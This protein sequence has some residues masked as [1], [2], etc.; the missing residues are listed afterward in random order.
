MRAVTSNDIRKLRYDKDAWRSYHRN[1]IELVV[2]PDGILF[3]RNEMGGVY[4]VPLDPKSE[5]ICIIRESNSSAHGLALSKDGT[6]Y[7]RSGDG[8]TIVLDVAYKI[9]NNRPLEL[10]L[11][12][13]KASYCLTILPENDKLV[14][15]YQGVHIWRINKDGTLDH[16]QVFDH[17]V[18]KDV[19]NVA[20][21]PNGVIAAMTSSGS[22]SIYV[23]DSAKDQY[24]HRETIK[25]YT[26]SRLVNIAFD[27]NNILYAVDTTGILTTWAFDDQTTF[28]ISNLSSSLGRVTSFSIAKGG[29]GFIGCCDGVVKIVELWVQLQPSKPCGYQLDLVDEINTSASMWPLQL[30]EGIH[31]INANYAD[32][33][34]VV[35]RSSLNFLQYPARP[36][37]SDPISMHARYAV[38]NVY[39]KPFPNGRRRDT[40]GPL[41]I[42]RAAILAPILVN[43]RQR[44][45]C[46]LVANMQQDDLK[47][48][49]IALL[50][51]DGG[52][53]ADGVD[54][55]DKESALLCYKYLAETLQVGEHTARGM[56][57]VIANK[58]CYD[59]PIYLT[60]NH[61]WK[62]TASSMM[63]NSYHVT[64]HDAD[65]VDNK[66]TKLGWHDSFMDY[67][68]AFLTDED[69]QSLTPARRDLMCVLHEVDMLLFYTGD[70]LQYRDE[71]KRKFYNTSEDCYQLLLD[72][73]KEKSLNNLLQLYAD[74]Q[75]LSVEQ[76][77]AVKLDCPIVEQ[78]PFF[79]KKFVSDRKDY[80]LLDFMFSFTRSPFNVFR[81]ALR[82]PRANDGAGLFSLRA[83]R[84]ESE[85]DSLEYSTQELYSLGATPMYS[86]EQ[87]RGFSKAT[88]LGYSHPGYG[89]APCVYRGRESDEIGVI[90]PKDC[91]LIN[92]IFL[93]DG[94]FSTFY[95]FYEDLD[96]MSVDMTFVGLKNTGA[97][98]TSLKDLT[99]R[100]RNDEGYQ[101]LGRLKNGDGIKICLFRN[102]SESAKKKAEIAAALLAARI[103]LDFGLK[104]SPI[105]RR[106]AQY[107]INPRI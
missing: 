89:F 74:G 43:L 33:L 101:I 12:K 65:C 37:P 83:K 102:D 81:R 76:A 105:S 7:A 66:R 94:R 86:H 23:F 79:F 69:F 9:K 22:C 25:I 90:F 57:N 30:V 98:F 84:S 60:D 88:G 72:L 77:K 99:Q 10:L 100:G 11:Q 28:K 58:D 13:T 27:E 59:R 14:S 6:L 64:V 17:E 93:Y 56:A 32:G 73:M 26:K 34:Y 47:L 16:Q 61:E 49:Q 78:P 53:K 29:Y 92:R 54:Y 5:A 95:R 55:W 4:A 19:D 3:Y 103:K 50:Y 107:K 36:K 75:V 82:M 87:K 67:V 24:A 48:V 70:L 91:V 18:N 42:C 2:S 45:D 62:K 85:Q 1:V 71:A 106:P 38:E 15:A 46:S 68:K 40:H 20:I 51:H 63:R 44:R 52:R 31:Y 104:L 41:H 39:L 97:I 96:K 21:A 35:A 8:I 80:S